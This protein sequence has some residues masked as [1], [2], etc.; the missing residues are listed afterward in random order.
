MLVVTDKQIM[1]SRK[2]KKTEFHEQVFEV[3]STFHKLFF[4]TDFEFPETDRAKSS[5]NKMLEI[6]TEDQIIAIIFCH[7]EW[8]GHNG[9]DEKEFMTVYEKGFPFYWIQHR[10]KYYAA[11]IKKT[12]GE[13]VWDDPKL[14]KSYV[15]NW[16]IQL[17]T[18]LG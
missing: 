1:S 5:I 2:S 10:A 16:E 4:G 14:L 12:L 6:Y 17:F 8:R 15:D 3:Y 7:F 18:M 13:K 9:T 11:Y